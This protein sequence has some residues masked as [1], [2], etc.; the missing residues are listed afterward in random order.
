MKRVLRKTKSFRI[1]TL[2]SGTIA[3][4]IGFSYI[5]FNEVLCATD[6]EISGEFYTRL[7]FKGLEG[8][9]IKRADFYKGVGKKEEEL[10]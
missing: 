2:I 6:E 5:D 10:S 7:Y 4:E 9:V 8:P 3:E 1:K